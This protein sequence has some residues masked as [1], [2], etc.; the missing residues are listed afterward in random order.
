MLGLKTSRH[1]DAAFKRRVVEEVRRG[2]FSMESASR[3]YGIGGHTTI[4]KWMRKL[5]LDALDQDMTD[6]EKQDYEDR[7]KEL[8]EALRLARMK[9]EAF[10]EMINIAEQE[11]KIPIRKKSN[12]KQSKK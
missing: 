10:D 1:Y 2:D 6:K 9:S 12:T 4:A 5:D 7:I 8:T 11:F 3:R